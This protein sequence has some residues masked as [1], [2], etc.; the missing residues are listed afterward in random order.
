MKF[1]QKLKQ[2][3]FKASSKIEGGVQAVAERKVLDD[4]ALEELEEL[5]IQADLGVGVAMRASAAAAGSSTRRSS[6]VS[7]KMRR[8]RGCD[9]SCHDTTSPS[10][11][12]HSSTGRTRVP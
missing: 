10:R 5:L 11:M 3:L 7:A 2:R 9:G 1:F 8:I 12:F 4:A 6:V